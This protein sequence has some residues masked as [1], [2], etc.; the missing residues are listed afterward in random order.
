MT[1]TSRELIALRNHLG[2][3]LDSVDAGRLAWPVVASV[4][5]PGLG[6]GWGG[7]EL[8]AATMLGVYSGGVEDP[9]AYIVANLR[10]LGT[11]DPPREVTPTPP[12]IGTVQ[13]DELRGRGHNPTSPAN[14]TSWAQ[15]IR[16]QVKA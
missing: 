9:A 13:A 12:P 8:A 4:A 2:A 15:H 16:D 14:A 11:Q 1:T 3:H 6:R 7:A 10:D 5:G